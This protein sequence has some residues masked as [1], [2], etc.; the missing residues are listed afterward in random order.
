[1]ASGRTHELWGGLLAAGGG[2]LLLSLGQGEAAPAFAA[3]AALSTFFLSPDVDHPR[4]RATRRWGPLRPLLAP[5]QALFPHRSASH[6]Y[7]TG[8][9]PA[10]PTRGGSPP[11]SSPSWEWTPAGRRRPWPPPGVGLPHGLAP[12]GL[13]P[14]PPGRGSPEEA[15][16]GKMISCACFSPTTAAGGPPTRICL[17]LLLVRSP[18]GSP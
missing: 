12:G 16:A 1:M 18:S 17:G 6:A 8:P 11:S 13:A 4:S 9:S 10:R 15:P 7:L 3:G 2:L 5:Y 14:P